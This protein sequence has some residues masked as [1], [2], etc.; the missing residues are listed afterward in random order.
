MSDGIALPVRGP[1]AAAVVRFDAPPPGDAPRLVYTDLEAADR[2]D[3]RRRLGRSHPLGADPDAPAG[4]DD[5]EALVLAAY[6][7]WGPAAADHLGGAFAVAVWDPARRA[8]VAMRDPVGLRP[9]VYGVRGGAVVVGGDVRAALATGVVPDVLDDDMVAGFLLGGPFKPGR[10]GRTY[11]RDL[12]SLRGGHRLVATADG[13]RT[14]RYWHPEATPLLPIRSIAEAGEALRDAIRAAARDAVADV[15]PGAVGAHLTSGLD[16]TSVAAFAAEALAA[17]GAAPPHAFCWQPP[18]GDGAARRPEYVAITAMAR[19]WAMPL[20]YAPSDTHDAVSW[21]LLDVTRAPRRMWFEE[22]GARRAATAAGVEMMLSG[23][24]GDEAASFDG[25]WRVGADLLRA[26]RWGPVLSLLA[27]DPVTALRRVKAW[28]TVRRS[29]DSAPRSE[30]LR[31][32][33]LRGE[34]QSFATLDLL[35]RARIPDLPP[36]P[37]GGAREVM[38]WQLANGPHH[39]RAVAWTLAGAAVG[40]RYRFPLLERRVLTVALGLPLEA[41]FTHDRLRRWPIRAAGEGLLPDEVRL[42]GKQEPIVLE[43]QERARRG[44][45][46]LVAPRVAV[47][48]AG[49]RAAYVNV[50]VLQDM[51]E[52]YGAGMWAAGMLGLGADPSRPPGPDGSA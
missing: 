27:R 29:A 41:L 48:A 51:L 21:A 36:Y 20:T 50:P 42:G 28:A 5:D 17:A 2:G 18:P 6:R 25:R 32:S 10:F 47:A 23:Y 1:L 8:V 26:G 43:S 9:L 49:N 40:M 15:P 31:Q 34:R 30:T 24:G 37:G 22:A 39:D 13:V 4:R 46:P 44:A 14:E 35:R 52:T 3:L 12:A 19:H 45:P 38:Y 16:S 7:R 11:L 33:A